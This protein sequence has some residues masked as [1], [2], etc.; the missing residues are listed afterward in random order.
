[1]NSFSLFQVEY[2]VISK[3]IICKVSAE[4]RP[5]RGDL[6]VVSKD[7]LIQKENRELN[8]GSELVAPIYGDRI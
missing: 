3:N 2:E 5:S 8:M 4:I 1:L 7:L 6:L